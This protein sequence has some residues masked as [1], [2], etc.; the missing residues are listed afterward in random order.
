MKKD[1]LSREIQN[2]KVLI[3]PIWWRQS[4]FSL[5][6]LVLGFYFAFVS[7]FGEFASWFGMLTFVTFA[8]LNFL[9]LLC[10]WSCLRIDDDGYFLRT[11]WRRKGFAHHEIKDFETREYANRKLIVVLLKEKLVQETVQEGETIPFPCTFGRPAEEVL[12]LLK[13]NLRN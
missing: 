5:F 8:V 3:K 13:K 1:Q 10:S 6:I 7:Y 9:E 4:L 2:T 12:E 11:W